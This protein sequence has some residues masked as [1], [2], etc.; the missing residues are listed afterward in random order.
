MYSCSIVHGVVLWPPLPSVAAQVGAVQFHPFAGDPA[1]EAEHA[2]LGVGAV[3]VRQA[4]EQEWRQRLP[5]RVAGLAHRFLEG[6]LVGVDE[7]L[8]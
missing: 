7:A 6:G 3:V 5:A 4:R 1:L 2:Q 8:G